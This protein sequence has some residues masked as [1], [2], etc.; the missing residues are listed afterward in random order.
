M[1]I[2]ACHVRPICKLS[3]GSQIPKWIER[4]INI[5]ASSKTP[6]ERSAYV[7]LWPDLGVARS[8]ATLK[9]ISWKRW[10][11]FQLNCVT[12]ITGNGSFI[13]NKKWALFLASSM[14]CLRKP[15]LLA[16]SA[17]MS[18]SITDRQMCVL[19]RCEWI[20]VTWAVSAKNECHWGP[21]H[22]YFIPDIPAQ[23]GL[24]VW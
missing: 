15:L 24:N 7:R 16:T 20:T 2:P 4:Y 8:G 6:N 19:G 18:L 1:E 3:N 23:R 11:G 9:R 12:G 21:I 10:S 13:Y 22:V 17:R 14:P 5:L